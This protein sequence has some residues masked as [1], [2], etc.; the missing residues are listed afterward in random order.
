MELTPYVD[1]LRREFT[2]AAGASGEEAQALAGR[3]AAPLDAATRL[4]FLELLSA[5]AEDISRGLSPGSVEVRMHGRDPDFVVTAPPAS[6]APGGPPPASVRDALAKAVEVTFGV[7]PAAM[8]HEDGSTSRV[9]L[10]LPEPLKYRLEDAA[11][12]EGLSVNSWLV[13]VVSAAIELS[14]ETRRDRG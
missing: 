9:T 8:G 1:T 5:A 7:R 4:T 3:L 10:R 6:Q 11:A 13:R 14:E 2:A 12:R